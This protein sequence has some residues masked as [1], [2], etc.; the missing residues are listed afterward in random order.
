[1]EGVTL[2]PAQLRDIDSVCALDL[3]A[4]FFDD[5]LGGMHLRASTERAV[6]GRQV[7]A[8]SRNDATVLLAE[9]DGH[10]IGLAALTLPSADS[11]AAPLV[12]AGRAAAVNTLSVT[13]GER[14]RGIGQLLAEA[15]HARATEAGAEVTLVHYASVNPYSTRFWNAQGYRPLWLNWSAP[16]TRLSANN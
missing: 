16:L 9:R 7:A 14:S 11:W 3:E 10:P 6:R 13:E 15:V 1:M 4:L 2:R 8:L 12:R 5:R